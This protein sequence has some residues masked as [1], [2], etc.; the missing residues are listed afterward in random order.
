MRISTQQKQQ[1]NLKYSNKIKNIEDVPMLWFN[2]RILKFWSVLIDDN[3]RQYFTYIPFFILN[4]FQLMDLCLTQKELNDKIHDIYMTML[5]FNTFLRT[6]V[7]VSNRKKF[8][9][10]LEHIGQMYE[11]LM[12]EY[13][14]EIHR[15][16]EDHTAMVLK[17]SKINFIMGMLTAVGFTVFPIISEQRGEFIKNMLILIIILNIIFEMKFATT[18]GPLKIRDLIFTIRWSF[19]KSTIMAGLL[20]NPQ[21]VPVKLHNWSL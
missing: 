5:M 4:V 2:V 12:M 18:M 17:I 13:D 11:D 10:L 16:M 3:W 6:V 20:K 9:K 21:L 7:M 15:I 14:S 8:C 19:N 1:K